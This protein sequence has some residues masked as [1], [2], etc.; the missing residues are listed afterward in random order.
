MILSTEIDEL[1][2]EKINKKITSDVV[3]AVT[4]E[5]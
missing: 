2:Q 3:L 1:E 5:L 4:E